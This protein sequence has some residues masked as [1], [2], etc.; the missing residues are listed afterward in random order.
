MLRSCLVFS[1]TIALIVGAV[2]T[3]VA[4]F[5]DSIVRIEE[6]PAPARKTILQAAKPMKIETVHQTLEAGLELYWV[7]TTINGKEF[8][9][10]VYDDGT[11][12][13]MGANERDD[14]MKFAGCPA[15]VKETFLNESNN[16]KF[17]EVHRLQRHGDVILYEAEVELSGL[18]Y[19]LLIEANGTLVE[20]SR[21][22]TKT[23]VKRSSLPN[24]VEKTLKRYA[25]RAQLRGDITRT[26][27]VGPVFYKTQVDLRQLTYN[28]KISEDGS[29]LDMSLV[30]EPQ[31]NEPADEPKMVES[32]KKTKSK[33]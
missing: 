15:P 3:S 20:K 31:N 27:A 19:S 33:K 21:T 28:I 13:I 12:M 22:F 11:L 9:I 26:Q 8:Q 25:P 6:I 18:R 17:G 14:V 7:V 16:A 24:A 2:C 30:F 5:G 10:S 1:W 32:K 29:L 23:I 4:Q